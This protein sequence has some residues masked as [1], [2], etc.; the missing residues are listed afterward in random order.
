MLASALVDTERDREE[1]GRQR[2]AAFL[3]DPVAVIIQLDQRM[4]G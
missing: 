2:K 1:P 4:S 3:Y